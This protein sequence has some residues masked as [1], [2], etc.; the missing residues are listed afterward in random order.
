MIASASMLIPAAQNA[1]MKCPEDLDNKDLE[2][3]KG[4]FPHFYAFCILQLCRPVRY[5]GE[6]HDNAKLIS[7]ISVERVMEMSIDDYIKA[8][9]SY[10]TH[11]GVLD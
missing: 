3:I 6:H 1:G 7:Q 9:L 2:K 10:T 8:G 4:D 11:A 5:H